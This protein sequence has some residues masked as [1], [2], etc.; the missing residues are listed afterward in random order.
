M[1]RKQVMC[2]LKGWGPNLHTIPKV[3]STCIAQ[4]KVNS[5]NL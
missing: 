4:L 1:E 2:G 5:R 3:L